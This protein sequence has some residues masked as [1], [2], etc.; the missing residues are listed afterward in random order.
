MTQE[1]DEQKT[2]AILTTLKALDDVDKDLLDRPEV[3]HLPKVLEDDELPEYVAVNAK[4][5]V[6]F[7]TDR[8]IISVH[9]SFWTSSV[10]KVDSYSYA[11]IQSITAGKGVFEHPLAIVVAGETH[12]LEADKVSRYSFAEYV[13]ARLPEPSETTL[14]HAKPTKREKLEAELRK[15]EG[16]KSGLH[17]KAERID[18]QWNECKPKSWGKNMYSGERTMLYKIL[19]LDEDIGSLIGGTYRAD[20]DRLHPHRGIAV[21]TTKRVI[22]VDKGVLGSTE[23]KEM[24]YRSIEATTYSAG[25]LMAGVQITGRGGA[26]FRIEDIAGKESAQPFADYVRDHAEATFAQSTQVPERNVLHASPMMSVADEIEKL[27][28]LLEKG[29]LTQDEFNSKKRDLLA[30]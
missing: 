12:R 15:R 25:M 1:H 24:P 7:A 13:S 10:S 29:I 28:N 6:A 26:S 2:N 30:L 9:K 19:D 22:F 3:K 16:L 18:P 20:T 17:K 8:R 4:L 11:E 21:A 14:A 23:V 27:A 5:S